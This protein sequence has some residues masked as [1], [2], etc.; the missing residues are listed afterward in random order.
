MNQSEY[1]KKIKSVF[2][3]GIT[4]TP[5]V[6]GKIFIFLAGALF[7]GALDYA[8]LFLLSR[9]FTELGSDGS[10]AAS[11]I[12]RVNSSIFFSNI[13]FDNLYIGGIIIILVILIS[14]VS[15]IYVEQRSIFIASQ[16]STSIGKY[17]Y[18][19]VLNQSYAWFQA[20]DNRAIVNTLSKEMG[21]LTIVLQSIFT[22]YK[23]MISSLLVLTGFY[24]L[25]PS[26]VI[27]LLVVFI[28][29][30][31]IY[32][33]TVKTIFSRNSG[34][35]SEMASLILG[36]TSS[37]FA[38]VRMVQLNDRK[39]FYYDQYAEATTSLRRARA[40]NK[41]LNSASPIIT[42]NTLLIIILIGSLYFASTQNSQVLPLIATFLFAI[43][44]L[45]GS[46]SQL[47][48]SYSNI[49]SRSKAIE[50][51]YNIGILDE[52]KQANS[53]T[54]ISLMARN[55]VLAKNGDG[56]IEISFRNVDYRYPGSETYIIKNFSYSFSAPFKTILEGSSGSGKS[57]LLD[58]FTGLILPEK[59]RINRKFITKDLSTTMDV[60]SFQ[61][62]IGYVPQKVFLANASIYFNI[63]DSTAVDNNRIE[64]VERLLKFVNLFELV[65]DLPD[66]IYT[67]VRS[68][69]SLSSTEVQ[70]SGGQI[71]RIGIARALYQ[72]PSILVLDE[73]L[74][75]LDSGNRNIIMRRLI[76]M[77]QDMSVLYVTHSPEEFA[78]IFNNKISL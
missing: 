53:R 55:D 11:S 9:Y 12:Q 3:L 19:K 15:K 14:A 26:A 46:F 73:S 41:F 75:A 49:L 54:K 13:T 72:M 24:I 78:E 28:A 23:Q 39:R 33:A 4:K 2:M 40:Q 65:Q 22:L 42:E 71:Q 35:E 30:Y 16:M 56:F 66:G 74:S 18:S 21:D 58:L 60:K 43:K 29:I 76:S 57:T 48:T 44:R 38:D 68:H 62:N 52:A 59:G 1:I 37:S 77:Y 69:D 36:I 10:N 47:F 50:N 61:N 25:Y 7:A 45:S 64:K 67:K 32:L 27:T 17:S 63:T 5:K 31:G 70:L 6:K 20:V 34:K 51:I 8:L